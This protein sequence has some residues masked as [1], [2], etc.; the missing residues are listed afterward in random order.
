[1]TT[2]ETLG[3]SPFILQVD[4]ANEAFA[5]GNRRAELGRILR[6]LA[7]QLE[8]A[9]GIG[10]SIRDINGNAVGS[11]ADLTDTDE[12]WS[13]VNGASAESFSWWRRVEYLNGAT[14]E[15]PGPN[16]SLRL[17]VEDPDDEHGSSLH[18]T[19]TLSDLIDAFTKASAAARYGFDIEDMDACAADTVWQFACFGEAVYG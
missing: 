8:N 16:G 1:M 4:T 10:G 19:L 7:D 3:Q 17:T 5:H 9:D 11:F 18:F 6:N 13:S 12:F 2:P 15:S 14:W